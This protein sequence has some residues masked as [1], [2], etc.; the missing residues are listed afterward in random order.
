MKPVTDKERVNLWNV[1][2]NEGFGY[3]M[4]YYGPDLKLIERMGF[5][6]KEVKAA[7]KLFSAIQMEIRKAE[8]LEVDD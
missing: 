5:N 8:K 1:V 3:Y 2:E 6:R 7:I 4:L